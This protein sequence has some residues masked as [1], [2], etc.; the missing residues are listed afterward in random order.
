[1]KKAPHSRRVI[2]IAHWPAIDRSLWEAARPDSLLGGSDYAA[3][4]RPVL[5]DRGA[6]DPTVPPA[7]RVTPANAQAFLEALQACGNANST[8]IVRLFD[9]R[10]ALRI[11]QPEV[12]TD[13]LTSPGGQGLHQRF[14][15]VR[16]ELFVPH[17]R[18]LY[19]WG[20]ELMDHVRT[21]AGL[22]HRTTFRNGLI[23]ALLAARAPR[24][25]ALSEMRLGRNLDRHQT[26]IRII[27]HEDNTKTGNHLE[28]GLPDR[29]NAEM[30]HYLDVVR[31][32]LLARGA[33]AHDSLWVGPAGAPFGLRGIQQM[34]RRATAGR[35]RV[36]FG[37]HRARHAMATTAPI[38]DPTHPA[39][40]AAMLGSSAAAVEAHYNRG[41]QEIA[42]RRLQASITE[43]RKR[44][45]LI[46]E[47]AFP[48][49]KGF[50]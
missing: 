28:Y 21:G 26:K 36:A 5:L 20:L 44:T 40:P 12:D 29:L 6:L 14:T 2:P 39:A 38:A 11:M 46:A 1:M 24:I 43:Q 35:F 47:R 15:I 16:R 17:S 33:H 9:L 48:Q 3:Q 27:F 22:R 10:A 25:R 4:L 18:E 49:L 32:A 7:A 23:I 50:P 13:W 41:Q 37:P 8:I 31:P 42:A 34:Y 30:T 19:E 45:R